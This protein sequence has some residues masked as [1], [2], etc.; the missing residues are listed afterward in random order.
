MP[1]AFSR[2]ARLGEAL[3]AT[4]KRRE[5]ASLIASYLQR[6]EPEEIGPGVRLVLGQIF[7][8][9]DGRSLN[10]SW[11]AVS[12][13]LSELT[14]DKVVD[15]RAAAKEAVD[16]GEVAQLL[17]EAANHKPRRPALKLLEVYRG[18]EEISEV[19]GAGSQG[20]KDGLLRGLLQRAPPQQAKYLVKNVLGE[21]R[22]G[23]SEGMMV[24][25][26]AQTAGLRASDVRRA[27]QLTGDIGRVAEIALLEGEE[28]LAAVR[29]KLF[30]PLKPMLAQT[31]DAVEDALEKHGGESALEHKVD[32]ARVQIHLK[33]RRGKR[34][35]IRIYSRRLSDVTGSLPDVA[36]KVR[37]QLQAD[38]AIV[39]GEV[40]A[41]DRKGRPLPFQDLMRR[42]RRVHGIEA[43]AKEVPVRLLLFD[44]LYRDGKSLVDDEYSTRWAALEAMAGELGTVAREVISDVRAGE[45]FAETAYRSG[46]EG[47]MAKRPDSAYTPGVRGKSWFKIK[48]TESLDLVIVA[49]E[50]GYGR[51]HGWLSNYHL[52]VRDSSSGEFLE[53]GKTFKG[54][55]DAEF[56]EMTDRLLGLERNRS[57]G[58]V[59]VEPRTVVEVTFNEIQK[60]AQYPS[61][62]ALRFARITRIRDDKPP[63]QADTLQTLRGLYERQFRTKGRPSG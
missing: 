10:L 57:G 39:E 27:N 51:R 43:V 46:H 5:L 49:A 12:R 55:T 22:H 52:A 62:L 1:T 3:E 47:V 13:I 19:S 38:E 32:G 56:K 7:P 4:R 24:E 14:E 31:A 58:T 63:G 18:F 33:R 50:W 8:E 25:A 45:A 35:R 44:V 34:D 29:P 21:M 37:T 26:I 54:L 9:W 59:R 11:S 28:G 53:V 16:A 2:V 17:L 42:F 36:E 60:S 61:G 6:L 23:A 30:R 48:R 40:I 15:P 20:R 41:V